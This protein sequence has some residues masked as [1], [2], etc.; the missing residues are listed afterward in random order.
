M[1]VDVRIGNIFSRCLGIAL[2]CVVHSGLGEDRWTLLSPRPYETLEV[3]HVAGRDHVYMGG[4][5]GTLVKL[6]RGGTEWVAQGGGKNRT[7]VHL[8]FFDPVNGIALSGIGAVFRTR[9]GG[10]S[11]DSLFAGFDKAVYGAHFLDEFVGYVA[12]SHGHIHKTVDGGVTWQEQTSGTDKNL[13][14]IRFTDAMHGLAFPGNTDTML[15]VT[16]DGGRNWLKRPFGDSLR[17]SD[18]VFIHPDTAI[19]VGSR[20]DE[21]LRRI[22]RSTDKGATWTNAY[23]TSMNIW[24]IGCVKGRLAYA[25]GSD[26]R[27]LRTRDG[28]R[29]WTQGFLNGTRTVHSV[30][31]LDENLGYAVGA[32]GSIQKSED[33]GLS[34]KPQFASPPG[35]IGA[36]DFVHGD[37]G[38]AVTFSEGVGKGA[39][40][41]DGG[42]TWRTGGLSGKFDIFMLDSKR[43]F[44]TGDGPI[45]STESGGL[46]WKQVTIPSLIFS[47][48][49]V[50]FPARDT[51]YVSHYDGILKSVD[52]GKTWSPLQISGGGYKRMHFL[53]SEYGHA[54]GG[55]TSRDYI[56]RTL[57][58]GK[59]WKTQSIGIQFPGS[60]YL[61]WLGI[62]FPHRLVGYV[63]GTDGRIAKTADAGETW[64]AQ[65]T[66]TRRMLHSLYFLD[67]DRGYAVGQA[68]TVLKTVDG[69]AS[70]VPQEVPTKADLIDI[71]CPDTDKCYVVGDSGTVLK[72][73]RNTPAGILGVRPTVAGVRLNGDGMPTYV[74]L[75]SS[76]VEARLHY[77]DGRLAAVLQE[78]VQPAGTH[79]LSLPSERLGVGVHL[80]VLKIDGNR[81]VFRI[82]TIR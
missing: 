3:V 24:S 18:L 49:G 82:R 56:A 35:R 23:V 48:S 67:P 38:V 22:F 7:F 62:H 20:G 13:F 51:G 63:S 71:D 80:L 77:L 10:A 29:T 72:L 41:H 79:A 70:W 37:T 28:G 45:Y 33:G 27:F 57:D 39:E 8:D 50:D 75:K 26:G 68:G 53:D 9:D 15:L 4:H 12:G 30:H 36:V 46:G 43:G 32:F 59:T 19:A 17:I 1:K 6:V 44:S 21:P 55:T 66:G 5:A 65:E 78:G 61:L 16:T 64:K 69:G 76:R 34:W 58:G 54:A 2:A 74:L 14:K 11:W 40:T 42:V 25:W 73:W 31:F 47:S 52:G 81:G 60:G